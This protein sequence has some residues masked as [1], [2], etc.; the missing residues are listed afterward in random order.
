MTTC[1][2]K[3]RSNFID[4]APSNTEIELIAPNPVSK[5]ADEDVA[6]ISKVV[7]V[8]S[9]KDI[10]ERE[11]KFLNYWMTTTIISTFTSFTATSSLASLACTPIGYT[12]AGCPGTG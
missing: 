8:S 11:A 10:D 9:S 6:E 12:G 7:D 4:D 5:F 1:K 2:R 3:K